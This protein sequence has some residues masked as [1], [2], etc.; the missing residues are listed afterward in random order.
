MYPADLSLCPMN[1]LLSLLSM[2]IIS[3]LPGACKHPICWQSE[4]PVMDHGIW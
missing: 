3:S 1:F 2:I 4:H